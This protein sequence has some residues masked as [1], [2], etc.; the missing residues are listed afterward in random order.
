MNFV[1]LKSDPTSRRAALLLPGWATDHR[2]FDLT[3]FTST[4]IAPVDLQTAD[5]A[6]S[7]VDYLDTHG[8]TTVDV[9]GWSLGGATAIRLART[10]PERIG[11][12]VLAGLRPH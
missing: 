12:L 10:R 3:R 7:L 5:I 9:Y 8:I 2:V 11:R 1:T 4:V 6:D